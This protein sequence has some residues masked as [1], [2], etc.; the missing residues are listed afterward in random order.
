M[1]ACVTVS[2]RGSHKGSPSTCCV[3]VFVSLHC[4]VSGCAQP[5]DA[6]QNE[7]PL[8]HRQPETHRELQ[9]SNTVCTACK[10]AAFVFVLFGLRAGDL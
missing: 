9:E 6:A 4:S 8:F 5:S 1:Y 3:Y 2:P 7:V 10:G